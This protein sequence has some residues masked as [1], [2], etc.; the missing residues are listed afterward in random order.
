MFFCVFHK[1][2]KENGHG[3]HVLKYAEKMRF[4]GK[5]RVLPL[6]I[7]KKSNHNILCAAFW[8]RY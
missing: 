5:R 2:K 3:Y 4:F 7:R 8:E 1:E 6:D